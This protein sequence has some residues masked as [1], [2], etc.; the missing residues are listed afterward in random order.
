[1]KKQLFKGATLFAVFYLA[2]IATVH[3]NAV[4]ACREIQWQP[5]QVYSVKS[6]L[7]QR[8]HIILPEP[9]QGFPVPGNPQLWDVDGEN[10]HLFVKPKNF[11]NHEGGKTT[12]T[13]I[14]TSNDSYDFIIER[15]KKGADT[16]I[17][18]VQDSM[19]VSGSNQGWKTQVEKQNMDLVQQVS[20]LK[21]KQAATSIQHQNQLIAERERHQKILN[22]EKEQL[23]GR[24]VDGVHKYKTSIY[25]RY[26]WKGGSGFL[27]KNNI[28]D[29]WDDGR[30][31]YVRLK[32]SNKGIMQITAEVGGQEEMIDYS[33]DGHSNLYTISGLFPEFI[34][35][36]EDA[37]VQIKRQDNLSL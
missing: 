9:I 4:S 8:T 5:Y 20:L 13:A 37:K 1:M 11:G 35:R 10:I 36:N 24:V 30:F 26:K 18:I 34:L 15:V 32:N 6:S 33:F 3:A 22:T 7:H 25:T 31:T 23:D 19:K 16:C 14:T 29:V 21:L 2:N 27:G 12:V 17:R 28:T